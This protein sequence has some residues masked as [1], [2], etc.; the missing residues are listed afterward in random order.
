MRRY[1]EKWLLIKRCLGSKEMPM[2]NVPQP[3][4]CW[5][6]ED[7]ARVDRVFERLRHTD[8]CDRRSPKTCHRKFGCRHNLPNYNHVLLSLFSRYGMREE[9]S[10]FLP[11]L[12]T[13]SK[14]KALD[15]MVAEIFGYL[16]WEFTP[17]YCK[18]RRAHQ[19]KSARASVNRAQ[20]GWEVTSMGNNL[21]RVRLSLCGKIVYDKIVRTPE[22]V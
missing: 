1:T 6:R 9:M 20:E 13:P 4:L 5:V 16:D 19:R 22:R 17:I 12:K 21:H 18:R 7:F 2:P 15:S 10:P 14:L 11:Q 3:V 8:L